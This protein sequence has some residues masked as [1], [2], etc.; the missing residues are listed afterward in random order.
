MFDV[1]LDRRCWLSLGP[2]E[3]FFLIDALMSALLYA[4][5]SDRERQTPG[6]L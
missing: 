1:T 3:T 6:T 5:R 4:S 2:I